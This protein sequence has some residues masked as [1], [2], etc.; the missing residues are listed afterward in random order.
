VGNVHPSDNTKRCCTCGKE[1]TLD[2]MTKN[3]K[4]KDCNNRALKEYH[5]NYYRYKKYGLS[6]KEYNELKKQQNNK[7]LICLKEK[8]LCIDH[9]HISGKVRGLLCR[10]CNAAIGSLGDDIK[11]IT[12][13]LNYLKERN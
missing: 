9:C 13:A 1:K 5:K 10:K 11:T 4:C 12:R 6:K 7:C 2:K 8:K 3:S